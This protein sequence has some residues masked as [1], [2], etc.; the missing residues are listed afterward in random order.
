MLEQIIAYVT[1]IDEGEYQRLV[2]APFE[3]LKRTNGSISSKDA[4]GLPVVR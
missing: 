3:D 1:D 2:D 4:P